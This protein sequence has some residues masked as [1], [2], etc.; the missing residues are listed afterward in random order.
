MEQENNKIKKLKN[1][2]KTLLEKFCTYDLAS[3]E[4][5]IKGDLAADSLENI[6][7]DII[8]FVKFNE[9]IN[10]VFTFIK[11]F[12]PEQVNEK[13]TIPNKDLCNLRVA[14]IQEELNELKEAINKEDCVSILDALID[15]QYVLD[16]AFIVFGLKNIKEKAFEEVHNS[17]MTKCCS[18][19]EQV[20]ETINFYK[21]V[22]NI[23]LEQKQIK[24]NNKTYYILYNEIGK[25]IKP[26][27]YTPPYLNKFI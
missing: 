3:N 18:N 2:I 27:H 17:N 1:N 15:L 21:T 16:G 9:S 26:L 19:L 13:P 23:K 11:T 10:K 24:I 8:N 20:Q 5:I 14:L 25:L 4:S 6:T 12:T 7:N 22:K